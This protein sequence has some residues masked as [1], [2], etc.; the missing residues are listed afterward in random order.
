MENQDAT[1]G[2]QGCMGAVGEPLV[3]VHQ[4]WDTSVRPR[5]HVGWGWGYIGGGWGTLVGPRTYGWCHGLSPDSPCLSEASP[6]SPMSQ[7]ISVTTR[8]ALRLRPVPE[9]HPVP[10]QPLQSFQCGHA[11]HHAASRD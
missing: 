9:P 2:L 6:Q 5:K 8:S 4:G 11:T 7:P 1:G 10:V 3:H